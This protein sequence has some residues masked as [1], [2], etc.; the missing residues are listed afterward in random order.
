MKFRLF[1][2]IA[3]TAMAFFSCSEE[4]AGIG[5]SLTDEDDR[6]QVT[7][8]IY[9]AHSNSMLIDSIYAEN[10]DCFFGQ[11]K[12]PETGAYVKTE[13][14][15]QF[16]LIEGMT[17][18][19]KEL[20]LKEDGDIIADSCEIRLYIDKSRCYGDS[21]IPMK[22]CMQ[23]LLMPM[24]ENEVYYTNYDPVKEGYI[25]ED[26]I[27]KRQM[28][29]IAN[30]ANS[31][32]V[33]ASMNY[34]DFIRISLNDYYKDTDGKSYLNYG[35]YLLQKYYEHPDYYKNSYTFVN[36]VCP[37]FYFSID[38]GL[39]VMANIY[40]M[41]LI[42]YYRYE[43][44]DGKI[45]NASMSFSATSEVLQTCH[46]SNEKKYLEELVAD[47]SCTYLKTPSG[48]FTEVEL[49]IDEI[50]KGHSNDSLLS[51]NM[52]F[53]RM[54]T[55]TSYYKNEYLVKAPSMVLMIQKD[56]L[57][58]F[59]EKERTYDYRDSYVSTLTKN[60]YNFTNM[61]NIVMLMYRAKFVGTLIDEDWTK[62][63][64]D[65]NKVV[66]VPVTTI[67]S[68]QSA[69]AATST[70][71]TTTATVNAICNNIELTSTRLVGGNTPIK[72]NVIYA[73]FNEKQ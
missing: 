19:S 50:M 37:G 10:F 56:S 15:T 62:K 58:S 71:T 44:S 52:A 40:E 31:D 6:L 33:R 69:K 73:K 41:D 13:F 27:N 14:M 72:I 48:I 22:M 8:G 67:Q 7:T 18:P 24:D 64:P 4:T 55:E 9:E 51:V 32:S 16:N 57:Y 59:F 49:P 28:F 63:H 38:D 12:D 29:T 60:T 3:V 30:H 21:L 65:W 34:I 11:I 46:V 35:S 25:R 42:I 26:G 54:N 36:K 5:K 47:K 1:T 23:E 20:M 68:N 43:K 61:G 66:L 53:Q 45:A 70:S 17:F 39:G 2:A